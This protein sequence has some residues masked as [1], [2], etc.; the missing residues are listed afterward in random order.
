MRGK[1]RLQVVRP[2]QGFR[3]L[4]SLTRQYWTGRGVMHM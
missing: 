1:V 3:K 2:K 4:A